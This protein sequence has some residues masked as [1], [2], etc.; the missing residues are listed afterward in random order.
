M[1]TSAI[2]DLSRRPASPLAGSSYAEYSKELL[3]AIHRSNANVSIQAASRIDTS[4]Y[5]FPGDLTY[6]RYLRGGE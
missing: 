4:A 1:K 3:D 6:I 2:I 5:E